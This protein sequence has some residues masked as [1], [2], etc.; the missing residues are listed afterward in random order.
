MWCVISWL[1]A[2]VLFYGL[3][4]LIGG[5]VEG[6]S[7]ESVYSTWSIAH[8]DLACAY[9]HLGVYHLDNLANPFALDRTLVSTD[10]RGGCRTTA[11]RAQCPVSNPEPTRAWML[12][13]HRKVLPLVGE[14][15][16]D[17]ADHSSE[18][19]RLAHPACGNHRARSLVRA[20]QDGVGAL[21]ALPRRV[22]ATG[23]HVHHVLLSSRGHLGDGADTLRR[24]RCATN[25][26]GLV[27][28]IS[29]AS[30]LRSTVRTLGWS[31]AVGRRAR[32]LPRQIRDRGGCRRGRHRR[33]TSSSP[34]LVARSK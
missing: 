7:S 15:L 2:S 10:Q 18:L 17:I 26:L 32:A 29:W 19:H 5:P 4:G 16:G 14:L 31:G 28:N 23:A 8:G 25:A 6:D 12:R 1:G 9:P 3:I 22:H 33:P 30:V 27:G 21:G 13:R 24:R 20:R 34:R 11:N